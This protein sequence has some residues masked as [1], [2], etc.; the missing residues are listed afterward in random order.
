MGTHFINW[1]LALAATAALGAAASLAPASAEVSFKGKRVQLIIASSAGG[2]TDRVG[3]LVATYMEKYLPGNPTIVI[4]NMGSGGGKIR[5]ANYLMNKAKPDGLTFMQSDG[6]VISPGT[7]RRRSARYDPRK[8]EYIGS[9]NRGGAV[10]FVNR[11]AHKRLMDK[12]KKPVIVAAISGTRSWQAM[13]MWGAEFFGWNVRWI[14]GYRGVGQMSKALRQGEIDIFATNNAFVIDQLKAD[15]VIDLL[16]QDGQL[17]DGKLSRR[18]SFKNVPVFADMLK[19][20]KISKLSAQGYRSVTASSQIDKWMGM[21]PGTPKAIV[22]TYRAA[23]KKSV[24]DPKFLAIGR[25]QFSKEINYIDG[26]T[27]AKMVLEVH[28]APGA[29]VDYAENLRKKYGLAAFKKKRKKKKKK[30]AKGS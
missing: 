11:K 20:A 29:A 22:R 15:G 9:L 19:K 13:P 3:R 12:S 1:R 17:I 8:F 6:T 10:L 14:P 7:L 16:V 28:S 18:P 21:P 5:A 24:N 25:K 30:K 27:V 2:G 23:Y 4:R 26:P